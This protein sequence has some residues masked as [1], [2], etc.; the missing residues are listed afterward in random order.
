MSMLDSFF[1]KGF[2]ATKCKT[3]LKLTIPRIKLLRNRREIQIKQMRRDIAKLLETGQEATAR[4]RVE[5]IIR[6]ENMMAAQEILELFCELISVRLP[7]IEAQRECPLDLKEAISS[8]CFAAPRCADLQELLQVQMLFVSKYGREFVAAATELMPECG[9]NRQLIELLSVRAPSPDVKLKLLKEIAEEHELD[10]DPAASETELL[11]KHEDLL[12]GPTQFVSG[13]KLPLPEEKH[14]EALNSVPDQAHNEQPDSDSDFETLDFPEVPKV[15]LRPSA[16]TAS[17]PEMLPIPPAAQRG[18]EH[19]PSNLSANYENLAQECHLENE[20]L[21]EEEPV[22]TKD[23]TANIVDAKEEKQFLPFISPPVSSTSFSTRPSTS[24]P[25]SRTKSEFNVDLQDVIAAAQ[26]AAE[27]AERAAAAARLAATLAQAR[28]SVL[29]KK[30]SEKFPECSDENPFHVDTPDQSPTTEKPH[31]GHQHSFDGPSGVSSYL[32]LHQQHE[33]HQPS[34]LHD[35]PSFEKLKME[36]D[37]PP[38]DL[39][40]EQQSVRHQPQ[41]LPSMDDDAYFS[42]PNLFTSQNPNLGSSAQS[43][44]G[45]SHSAHDV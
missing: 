23:G 9:V 31:F 10:W 26:A 17:A 1:N 35:L 18:I 25:I 41:R 14:E 11:K 27:T 30:N 24:P 42:Y 40:H 7:I 12:N 44:T 3:L 32:H 5:H 22:A 37:S 2:K 19:E 45:N 28:I 34:E 43:G 16:N 38:S 20:D 36:Y 8:I 13:S 39:V 6:E 4:I 15:A 33:D 21:T 29:T